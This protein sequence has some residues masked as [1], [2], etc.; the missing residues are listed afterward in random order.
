MQN[1]PCDHCDSKTSVITI[2]GEHHCQD[3]YGNYL[4][5]NTFTCADCG[6]THIAFED[7]TRIEYTGNWYCSECVSENTSTP[8]ETHYD[9]CRKEAQEAA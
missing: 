2:K 3:C 5:D 4:K 8:I 9:N 7:G 1:Q 6:A